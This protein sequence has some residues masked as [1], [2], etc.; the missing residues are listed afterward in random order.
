VTIFP[1]VESVCPRRSARKTS[2][3]TTG[4]RQSQTASPARMI[5]TIPHVPM[6]ESATKNESNGSPRW[7]TIQRSS[8]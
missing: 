7:W 4:L 6:R 2:G 3:R 5:Q 1:S 8:L